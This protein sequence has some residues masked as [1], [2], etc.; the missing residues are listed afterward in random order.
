MDKLDAALVRLA[1]TGWHGLLSTLKG[2]RNGGVYGAKIRAPHA[3]VMVF[4]FKEG[5][6]QEKLRLIA[7]LTFEHARNLAIFVLVYKGLI[8][9]GRLTHRALGL[10]LHSAGGMPASP[11]HALAA[12]AVGGWVV[13]ANYSGV[14]YQIV[15]YLLSRIVVGLVRLLASK[16]VRPFSLVNF[17]QTYPYLAM[18]VW[19]VVMWLYEYHPRVIHPSLASSMDFLYHD[20]N[21][22]QSV[23]DFLPTHVLAA[24]VLYVAYLKRHKLR[25]LL[26]LSKR[27]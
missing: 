13:W 12:G 4:L 17:K 2:F 18:G 10:P 25:D 20:A 5:S 7:K 21:S 9:S 16:Q 1:A 26:D 27:L 23:Q 22:W 14:N 3:L 6:M 8:A 15:L 24:A 19:A 11:L